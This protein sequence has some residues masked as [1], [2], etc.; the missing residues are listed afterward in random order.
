[1]GVLAITPSSARNVEFETR[2][3]AADT[4]VVELDQP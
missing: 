4:A 1:V 2:D 3:P